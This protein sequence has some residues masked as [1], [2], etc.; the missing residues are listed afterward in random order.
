MSTV[1]PPSSKTGQ[2]R[3][4]AIAPA[5]ANAAAASFAVLEAQIGYLNDADIEVAQA[6]FFDFVVVN[7]LFETALFDL[8]T[9]VHAQRLKYSAQRRNKSAVFKAL[10][11]L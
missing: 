1:T 5:A 9:I 6:Q 10:D 8:K 2:S 3:P 11:L 4:K 7:A